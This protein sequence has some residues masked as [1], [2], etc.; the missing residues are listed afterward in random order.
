MNL[1]V[2]SALFYLGLICILVFPIPIKNVAV[3]Y[4][5][6]EYRLSEEIL[7]FFLKLMIVHE[8]YYAR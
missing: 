6:Y 3:R 5:A 2:V 7:H 8:E 4:I 1:D